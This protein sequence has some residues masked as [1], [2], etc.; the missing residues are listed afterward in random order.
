MSDPGAA[1]GG[2][3]SP[4]RAGVA[5]PAAGSG[6]RMGG[7]RKQFLELAGE[8][9]LL[10]SLRPFLDHGSV[11]AVVVA[12]PPEDVPSPPE[13]LV[14]DERVRVVAGGA[15][16]GDSV[17][18]ALEAL[19]SDVDIILVHD[20]AR[21]L[22]TPEIIDRCIAEASKGWGAVAGWPLEDTV[23]EVD[24]SGQVARTLDRHRIWRAQTPQA[25]PRAMLLEA[26]RR[27]REAGTQATDDAA[28][29]EAA[30]GRVVMVEGSRANLKVTRPED[31]WWAET[32][33]RG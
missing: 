14:A 30:G 15:T 13:W 12:L 27:A 32:L 17:L 33:L 25:F 8:P 10:R 11:V 28:L 6:Q 1:A 19:P 9:V 23:K 20:G 7:R 4:V 22:V 24:I 16:R 29:V 31:L 2:P 5:V 21:P 18:A 26:Y 3:A